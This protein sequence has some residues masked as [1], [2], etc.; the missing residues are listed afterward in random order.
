[1]TFHP[2]RQMGHE[3]QRHRMGP[4]SP[5]ERRVRRLMGIA[6][7]THARGAAAL[8]GFNGR[9]IELTGTQSDEV[10]P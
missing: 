2:L 9:H 6:V 5:Q 10:Q 8:D 1:M 4:P 3:G 7:R